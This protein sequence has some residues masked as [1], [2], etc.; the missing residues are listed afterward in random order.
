M[1][2]EEVV[3]ELVK[4]YNLNRVFKDLRILEGRQEILVQISSTEA[5]KFD[6]LDN[7]YGWMVWI[8][9]SA[10]DKQSVE[11]MRS[12]YESNKGLIVY[13]NGSEWIPTK[14]VQMHGDVIREKYLRR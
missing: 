13:Y 14:L 12:V 9:N 1:K 7:F 4:R 3:N 6:K 10:S 2:I 8:E 5:I 11:L